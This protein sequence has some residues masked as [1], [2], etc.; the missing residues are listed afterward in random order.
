MCVLLLLSMG[1]VVAQ[2]QWQ[3][4]PIS[5]DCVALNQR[6]ATQVANG[7]LKEAEITLSSALGGVT[8]A[9]NTCAG[10]VLNN[11]ATLMLLSGRFVQAAGFAARS[12][13]AFEE[14]YSTDDP[15]LMSPLQI[16]AAARFDNGEIGRSREAFKR[17]QAIRIERPE[18]RAMLHGM[19]G[20]LLDI[21]GNRGDAECEYLIALRAWEEAGRGGTANA[22]VTLSALGSLYI[23]QQRYDDARRALDRALEIL[24][25][26]K[27]AV[28]WDRINLLYLRAGLHTR[29]SEW[30][31]AEK[32]LHDAVSMADREPELHLLE[33]AHVLDGYASVLRKNHRRREAR[34]IE[35]RAAALHGQSTTR[36]VIDA[37]ELL[38]NAKGVK[39]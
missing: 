19:A 12:I 15:V 30:L 18:D 36:A 25:S 13:H 37:T 34:S 35:A 39:K 9:D 31:E 11:L 32:D 1:E 24:T 2:G 16:L 7:R 33:L 22:G 17:M 4:V 20:S 10:V 21:E 26:A 14:S 23:K 3:R 6:V 5:A 28:P 27:D 8:R 38:A 29:Q